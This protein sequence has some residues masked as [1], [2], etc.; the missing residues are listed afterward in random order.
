[1]SNDDHAGT[2]DHGCRH[3]ELAQKLVKRGGHAYDEDN[4]ALLYQG[5]S[6]SASS[7]GGPEKNIM[8]SPHRI[9]LPAPNGPSFGG[10]DHAQGSTHGSEEDQR[11]GT[12]GVLGEKT[13][14]SGVVCVPPYPFF[15]D[16]LNWKQDGKELDSDDVKES[17]EEVG[18][19]DEQPYLSRWFSDK[20][21]ASVIKDVSISSSSSKSSV[22][23]TFIDSTS[24][25]FD[26]SQG[27]FRRR[28]FSVEE[29]GP[30]L[31]RFVDRK[32]AFHQSH[33]HINF[34]KGAGKK[35]AKEIRK[36]YYHDWYHTFLNLRM[37]YQLLSFVVLSFSLWIFFALLFMLVAE[38][39]DLHQDGLFSF[40]DAFILSIVTLETIGYGIPE[41]S[42]HPPYSMGE[43]W[44]GAV[45]LTAQA[46]LMILKNAILLGVL[47]CRISQPQARAAT[48][49]FSDNAL[50]QFNDAGEP[51][52]VFRVADLCRH[53]LIE[54][55]IRCYCIKYE[56]DLHHHDRN[57]TQSGLQ[58]Y[59]MRLNKPD[60]EL[61]GMLLLTTPQT[62]VHRIDHSSP[63]SPYFKP[64]N[65]SATQNTNTAKEGKRGCRKVPTQTGGISL[66]DGD[67]DTGWR[68]NFM[69]QVCG[70]GFLSF[71]ALERH[72]QYQIARG[73]HPHVEAKA[74][75]VPGD[76]DLL[77]YWKKTGFEVVV[78]FEGIEPLTS[79]ALQARHSYTSFSDI[80]F[81]CRFAPCMIVSR[82]TGRHIFNVAK[83]HRLIYDVPS[84]EDKGE[85]NLCNLDSARRCRRRRQVGVDDDDERKKDDPSYEEEGKRMIINLKTPTFSEFDS[86]SV[87]GGGGSSVGGHSSV[88]PMS[89]IYMSR[90]ALL[91]SKLSPMDAAAGRGSE[92]GGKETS[93]PSRLNEWM[94]EPGYSSSGR[95]ELSAAHSPSRVILNP[96]D[97]AMPS[98]IELRDN[99]KRIRAEGDDARGE[100]LTMARHSQSESPLPTR[101]SPRKILSPRTLADL[102]SINSAPNAARRP[103]SC[104]S[105]G[106]SR[107]RISAVRDWVARGFSSHYGLTLMGAEELSDDD[108]KVEL[109]E[110]SIDSFPSTFS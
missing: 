30:K 59:P 15:P 107:S 90:D 69:C 72:L 85:I 41:S 6:A 73:E 53:E 34:F 95:D 40:H 3:D 5:R 97:G 76:V 63:L 84:T 8:T 77:T 37:K 48:I 82:S 56:A 108:E 103:S 91:L 54:G 35:T 78:I 31:Y 11:G 75:R 18:P 93:S 47:F 26:M 19:E 45:I 89:P 88:G 4:D 46:L 86:S 29:E 44:Q 55:H 10:K 25:P 83:F 87:A 64:L 57:R 62:I 20:S 32:G 49:I 65:L 102:K 36:L 79:S 109:S 80:L 16:F 100:H 43:C 51:F 106:S 94:Q 92:S 60:D 71:G 39:C 70:D 66:R 17:L 22:S 9:Q 27:N 50:V 12:A 68:T 24:Y 101:S 14:K 21:Q 74:P 110:I 2:V 98:S 33:G 52:L 1:M 67:C 61:D 13:E 58:V 23:D 28:R 42:D 105:K 104:S 7:S 81:E 38:E 99:N 96:P